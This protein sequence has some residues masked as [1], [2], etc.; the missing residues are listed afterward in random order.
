LAALAALPDD[1]IDTA[2]IPEVRD[3]SDAKRGLF[4]RP[5]K[6]QLTLR[7]DADV[8]AWFKSRAPKGQGYQTEMNMALRD[9]IKR[10]ARTRKAS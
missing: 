7:I 1:Q 10:Q 4:Y 3:W 6:K 9:H 5:I 2:D 8:I